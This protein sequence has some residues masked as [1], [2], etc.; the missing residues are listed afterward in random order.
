MARIAINGLGRIG[1]TFLKLALEQPDFQVV[2]VNDIA[3]PASLAY[4]MKYDSV[5]GRYA[6]PVEVDTA[7]GH[8]SLRIG[9]PDSSVQSTRSRQ[10]A[11]AI[12][13]GGRRRRSDRHLRHVCRSPA[14]PSCRR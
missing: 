11:L 6:K 9:A 2:A 3:A 8:T 5:Y 12:A 14:P 13:C 1:R 4:L 7:D 10:S